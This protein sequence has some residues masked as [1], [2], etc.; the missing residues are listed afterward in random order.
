VSAAQPLVLAY[1]SVAP[2]MEARLLPSMI[3][4]TDDL[5]EHVGQ[6][7]AM[8]RRIVTAGELAAE[9]AA[10]AS[11]A[12]TAVLTFDDGWAD[13]LT[14][15]AP[16]LRELGVSATFFLCPGLFGNP[17]P[18]MSFAG[19]VLTRDEAELLHEAGMELGAHSMQHPDLTAVDDAML[20]HELA[21]SRRQVEAITGSA[22]RVMAYPFGAQDARVRRAAA[23]AG[24]ELAFTY[25]DGPWKPLAAP[26]VPMP[27]AGERWTVGT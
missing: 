10:G 2:R 3:T 21:E 1:H 11:A 26:R 24:Y 17:E 14:V 8:D 13:A 25:R 27:P 18:T 23:R 6:L 4:L 5:A 19:R 20:A 7:R 9:L 12:D 22:C 15:A 16:L